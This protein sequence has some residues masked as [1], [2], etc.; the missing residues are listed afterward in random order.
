MP[1]TGRSVKYTGIG[2]KD[3]RNAADIAADTAGSEAFTMCANDTAPAPVLI[4]PP[5]CTRECK[6]AI[7][8]NDFLACLATSGFLRNLEILSKMNT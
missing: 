3:L 7:N 8:A 6:S 1:L 4:T 5:I 2:R